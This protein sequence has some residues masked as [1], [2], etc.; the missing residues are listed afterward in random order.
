MYSRLR[1]Y[2]M[3]DVSLAVIVLF[4]WSSLL[5]YLSKH[6]MQCFGFTMKKVMFVLTL[7]VCLKIILDFRHYALPSCHF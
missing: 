2:F 4:F 5:F 6:K 1:I 7:S 3:E